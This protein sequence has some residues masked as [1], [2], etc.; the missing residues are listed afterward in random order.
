MASNTLTHPHYFFCV[1]SWEQK[2]LCLIISDSIAA[3][4]QLHNHMQQGASPLKIKKRNANFKLCF[5]LKTK[6]VKSHMFALLWSY[7]VGL[8]FLCFIPLKFRTRCKKFAYFFSFCIP[9]IGITI[10]SFSAHITDHLLPQASMTRAA[11]T[12]SLLYI[13]LP[14]RSCI[15]LPCRYPETGLFIYNS[16]HLV[17]FKPFCR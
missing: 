5:V 14:H 2:V 15:Y 16:S 13:L 10:R 12:L 8:H 17:S 11:S 3:H 9:S 1:L 4:I 7:P 6:P